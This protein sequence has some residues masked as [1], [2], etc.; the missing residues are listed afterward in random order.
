MPGAPPPGI[1]FDRFVRAQLA[2]DELA[3]YAPGGDVTPETAELLVATHFLR[4]APDGSGES[5]G[6]ARSSS[7]VGA[8][9]G[10]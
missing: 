2:G 5:D 10:A 9:V 7:M 8:C 3:G 6:S 4:N 1:S